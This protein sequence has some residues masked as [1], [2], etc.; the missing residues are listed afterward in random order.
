MEILWK[1][2]SYKFW[3]EPRSLRIHRAKVT[4]LSKNN[5]SDKLG[6]TIEFSNYNGDIEIKPP[7]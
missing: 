3:L 2:F 5:P 1:D 4:A 7:E 6:L